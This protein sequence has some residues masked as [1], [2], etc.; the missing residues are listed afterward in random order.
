MKNLKKYVLILLLIIP[1][2]Y[3]RLKNLGYSEFINDEIAYMDFLK[4]EGF[5]TY[6][7]LINRRKGPI[8]YLING[9]VFL[10]S[11]NPHNELIQRIPFALAGIT[12][13]Y[14]F[15]KFL[16]NIINH[17]WAAF[18]GALVIGLNGF[19]IA[20]S[21]IVQY[22]SF[23]FLFSSLSLY[24]YS[25]AYK[26]KFSKNS[27]LGTLFFC[28][29]FLSH[30]DAVIIV[31]YIF[32]VFWGE[33]FNLWLKNFILALVLLLP[34]MIPY[35]VNYIKSPETQEYFTGRINMD[36]SSTP[37]ERFEEIK[38]KFHLYN[39]F[40]YIELILLISM[41]SI[42]FIKK[43]WFY[44]CWL[45]LLFIYFIF[46][47]SRPGTHVYNIFFPL[48]VLFSI[49]IEN[50]LNYGRKWFKGAFIVLNILSASMFFY[51]QYL[52]YI[53]YESLYP[54]QKEKI[55]FNNNEYETSEYSHENLTNNIIGF[56]HNSYWEEISIYLKSCNPDLKYITNES[57]SI[58][59]YYMDLEYGSGEVYYAVGIK[60]PVS[61]VKD[62]QFS[63]LR[64][65]HTIQ[66]IQDSNGNTVAQIYLVDGKD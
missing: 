54:W 6:K 24:F 32:Y 53:D 14:F 56:P 12:G 35:L 34:F 19:F 15:Y 63:Q 57:K 55:V 8:P 51:T 41:F 16:K 60:D 30:W 29:S 49:S 61:F 22:Q 48:M 21:R 58:S 26:H 3:L 18:L 39:P 43:S 66:K 31:P 23:N 40:G 25:Q 20:F 5:Y 62:Y 17:K 10:I 37:K 47:F 50:I 13:V 44:L 7:N 42:L 59:S 64:G 4:N 45:G 9:G 2:A 27:L 36:I 38:F 46:V 1:I 11:R 28:L 33:K 52:I 65:K